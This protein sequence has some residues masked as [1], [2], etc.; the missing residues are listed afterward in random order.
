MSHILVMEL[1]NGR[2][3]YDSV[4]FFKKKLTKNIVSREV[5]L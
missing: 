3:Y 1:I 5:K 4:G 2:D